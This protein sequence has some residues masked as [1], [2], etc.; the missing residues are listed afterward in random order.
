MKQANKSFYKMVFALVMP[1]AVQNLINTAITSADVMMLGKVG[2]N[3]LSASSLAGQV[4]FILSL[5]F[6]GITSG[7]A[8]LTAQYWGKQD[9]QTIEKIM[10]IAMR[11][12]L[13]VSLIFTVIV[14]LFTRPVMQIFSNEE[15]VIDE[16]I[17]YLRIIAFSYIPIAI[18]MV[19]LNIVRSIERVLISTVVYSNSLVLNVALNALLIFGLGPFPT[20]G[21][22]GAAIAT[23]I[24][25]IVELIIVIA[26]AKYINKVI[27]FEPKDLFVR[28]ALLFKDFLKYASPVIANELFWGAACSMNAVII[29]HIGSSVVAANSVAQVTRQLAMVMA[30]GI[31]NATAIIIG[32]TIG[33]NNE[34]L[35]EE[36]GKR[37][38]KLSIYAG[39][40]GA[41]IVLIIRPIVMNVLTLSPEAVNY[42]SMMMFVMTYF[43][44]AQSINTTL[45]VGVFRAG[46]DTKFGLILD[47]TTMW[48]GS[49]LLGSI[50]AFVFKWPVTI[51]YILLMCDEIIKLPLTYYR[52]K[53]KKWLCH[54]T[55]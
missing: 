17:Q 45:V 16:G 33:E 53:G 3:V 39:L 30:F 23:L 10:G 47:V 20:L 40:L 36:Y 24:T 31:A 12:S 27:T 52:Y 15:A 32:K 54:V 38:L 11:I 51:V 55:R 9:T 37:F 13:I 26:Y 46:G 7:A 44:F 28:D 21:I 22:K 48:G 50:A 49:I 19:Y 42:L 4:Q 1:M 25:R 29:G 34:K 43:T 35:A 8:V 14:L 41:A 5:I 18:T 2:E 6:F